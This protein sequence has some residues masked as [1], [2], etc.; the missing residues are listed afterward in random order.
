MDGDDDPKK[1]V[2]NGSIDTN[3]SEVKRTHWIEDHKHQK[4][5]KCGVSFDFFNRRH[6]CR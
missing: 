3:S 4:C 5:M 2:R 1:K 6:H